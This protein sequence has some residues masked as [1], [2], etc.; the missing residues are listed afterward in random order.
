MKRP[1]RTTRYRQGSPR[2]GDSRGYRSFNTLSDTR[3]I[4]SDAAFAAGFG[5][6]PGSLGSLFPTNLD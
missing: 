3:R 2:L 4:L 1:L 5:Q 6:T